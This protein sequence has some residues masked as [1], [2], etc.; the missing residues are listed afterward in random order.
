MSRLLRTIALAFVLSLTPACASGPLPDP[1]AAAQSADQKA[2]A[3]I[4]AYALVLEEAADLAS[5]SATP[6]SVRDALTKAEAAATPAIELVKIAAVG[7]REASDTSDA[8]A[9]QQ[10]LVRAIDAAAAPVAALSQL[11]HR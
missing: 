5:N 8:L 3:L 7:V 9:R 1:F 6:Q 10:A 11:V 4:R 2:Y